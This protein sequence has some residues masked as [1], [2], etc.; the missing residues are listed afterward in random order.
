[1]LKMQRMIIKSVKKFQKQYEKEKST[2]SWC[3]W[4]GASFAKKHGWYF[5]AKTFPGQYYKVGSEKDFAKTALEDFKELCEYDKDAADVLFESW[6]ME[7][8]EMVECVGE[9]IHDYYRMMR[10]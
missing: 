6:R 2:R 5:M 1:M 4:L 8:N 3:A 9:D 10:K 7:I